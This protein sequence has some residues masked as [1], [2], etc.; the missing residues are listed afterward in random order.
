MISSDDAC[1]QCTAR[2]THSFVHLPNCP[3]RFLV[4]PQEDRRAAHKQASERFAQYLDEEHVSL[5]ITHRSLWR[6]CRDAI[7]RKAP[8]ET[9]ILDENDR[10]RILDDLVKKLIKVVLHFNP[11][12]L[13]MSIHLLER[14]A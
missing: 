3:Y 8:A 4:M 7:E 13:S 9:D 12:I 5:G 14:C 6:E 2:P 11:C 1:L 10:R